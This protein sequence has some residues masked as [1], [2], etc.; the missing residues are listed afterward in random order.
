MARNTGPVYG[1][2]IEH[3]LA[4]NDENRTLFGNDDE[5][6]R[7][8]RNKLGALTLL[9]SKD[10]E[11]SNNEPYREKVKTYAASSIWSQTLHLDLYHKKKGFEEFNN[12]HNFG[13]QTYEVFDG[14]AIQERQRI[15]FKLMKL[16]WI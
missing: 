6:F 7:I 1:F 10:N 4:N 16:I 11:A 9:R 13:F 8:E 5:L 3:I 12:R 15:L 14:K 2:H